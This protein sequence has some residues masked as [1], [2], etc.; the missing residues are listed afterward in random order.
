MKHRIGNTRLQKSRI[1][2][3][4]LKETGIKSSIKYVIRSITFQKVEGESGWKK[5]Q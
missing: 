5:K 2:K 4:G 1:E 3:I